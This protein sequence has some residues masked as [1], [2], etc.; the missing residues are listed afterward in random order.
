MGKLTLRFVKHDEGA[1]A[2]EYGL[3]A[4][5]ISLAIFLGVGSVGG[6]VGTLWSDNA[7]RVVDALQ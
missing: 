1:T 5:L 4:A 7:F 2:I 6:E 3:I